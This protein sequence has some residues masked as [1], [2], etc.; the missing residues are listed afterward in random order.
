MTALTKAITSDSDDA[1]VQRLRL[2]ASFLD[3][4]F[5]VRFIPIRFGYDAILGLIPGI[6]DTVSFLI[7]LYILFE[8]RRLGFGFWTR[9]RMAWNLVLDLVVGSIPV[10]GN[11]FDVVHK[12]S[13][14]NLRLMGIEPIDEDADQTQTQTQT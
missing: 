14:K 3:T 8:A 5:R 11:V 2:L 9:L 6:G 4:K 10:L 12:S 13:V 1:K 7:G